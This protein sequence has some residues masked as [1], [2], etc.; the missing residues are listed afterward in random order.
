VQLPS[1]LRVIRGISIGIGHKIM[2]EYRDG[3]VDT[4]GEVRKGLESLPPDEMRRIVQ[5][6]QETRWRRHRYRSQTLDRSDER[7]AIRRIALQT[8]VECEYQRLGLQRILISGGTRM[9][10]ALDQDIVEG[11][12]APGRQGAD[13]RIAVPLIN[14]EQDLGETAGTIDV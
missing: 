11:R 6:R 5:G 4:A 9:N 1:D 3:A 8:R 13:A 7:H 12:D 10:A 14:L 2:E